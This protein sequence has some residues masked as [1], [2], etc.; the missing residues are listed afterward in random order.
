VVNDGQG[1][2]GME[3][4][5]KTVFGGGQSSGGIGSSK[6][7]PQGGGGK[8][9]SGASF[10]KPEPNIEKPRDIN[11]IWDHHTINRLKALHPNIQD[12]AVAFI[13]DAQSKGIY[14]RVTSGFRSFAEQDA[15]FAQ[16]RTTSGSIVTNA[17]G[18]Q[19]Y[20]NYGLAIDVVEFRDG[21]ATT[22]N[23]LFVNDR[24]DEIGAIGKSH[25]FEWG[26]DWAGFPDRPH[27]QKTF[28]FTTAELGERQNQG[29]VDNGFVQLD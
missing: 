23:M 17:R 19:S 4:R 27:F 1:Q 11:D 13:L 28:G 10:K 9:N 29:L 25:G 6:P 8:G 7:R 15:L 3:L 12:A 21:I 2:A 16:G 5:K 14:L 26:G 22:E 20:H 24:W 18:G